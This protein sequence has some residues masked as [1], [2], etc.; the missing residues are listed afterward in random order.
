MV[1]LLNGA[2]NIVDLYVVTQRFAY[3]CFAQQIR[4]RRRS[5]CLF[6]DARCFIK[7]SVKRAKIRTVRGDSERTHMNAS[8]RV[9]G[10]DN[11][12][13]RDLG[14]APCGLATAIP[15]PLCDHKSSPYQ[16]VQ[17]LCHVID[18]N[19]GLCGDLLCGAKR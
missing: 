10:L 17:D 13:N 19:S 2:L 5:K 7:L 15:S 14:S 9:N 16:R 18:W 6:D 1:N 3:S 8:D 4:N 12:V 11:V